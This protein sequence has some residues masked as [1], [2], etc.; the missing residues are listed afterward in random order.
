MGT[1]SFLLII[2]LL[3]LALGPR[4]A[5]P[6]ASSNRAGLNVSATRAL[7]TASAGATGVLMSIVLFSTG[8][9]EIE[10]SEFIVKQVRT[11]RGLQCGSL[12]YR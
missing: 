2:L 11:L 10:T 7:S 9:Y 4:R 1:Q 6:T 3:N 5:G 12:T 8:C